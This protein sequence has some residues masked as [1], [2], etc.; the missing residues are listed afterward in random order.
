MLPSKPYKSVCFKSH[1]SESNKLDFGVPHGCA[2]GSILFTLLLL[3]IFLLCTMLAIV[4]IQTLPKNS[5]ALIGYQPLR[6][7]WQAYWFRFR[8]R[9]LAITSLLKPDKTE[10]LL[11]GTLPQLRKIDLLSSCLSFSNS[12][13]KPSH[14]ACNLVVIFDSSLLFSKHLVSV[15]LP[16]ITSCDPITQRQAAL[17]SCPGTYYF[18]AMLAHVPC[19]TRPFLPWVSIGTLSLAHDVW[20]VPAISI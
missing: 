1:T 3:V 19:L 13:I 12:L 20:T 4:I 18:Q 5:S 6:S 15:I 16:T 7:I 8:P 2:L 14:C 10:L 17:A 9:W 11:L